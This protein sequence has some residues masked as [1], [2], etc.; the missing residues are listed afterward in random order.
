MARCGFCTKTI[1]ATAFFTH[2]ALAHAEPKYVPN[3]DAQKCAGYEELMRPLGD[4]YGRLILLRNLKRYCGRRDLDDELGRLEQW[5]SS[6][7][8]EIERGLEPRPPTQPS[9][10]GAVIC[11]TDFGSGLA[12]TNC[13]EP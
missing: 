11:T 9:P 2:A 6:I 10:R 12:M 7:E 8:R 13:I 3:W 5:N 4:G 1:F